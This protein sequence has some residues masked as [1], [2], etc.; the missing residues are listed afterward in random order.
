VA[1]ALGGLLALDP[2]LLLAIIGM[3][4]LILLPLRRVM[5]SGLLAVALA[6][7]L[8]LILGRPAPV[9]GVLALLAALLWLAHRDHLR[10][11]FSPSARA[12]APRS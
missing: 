4:L 12:G 7:G 9:A 3:G 10:T 5:A 8:V 11:A 2:A 1:P 6:P